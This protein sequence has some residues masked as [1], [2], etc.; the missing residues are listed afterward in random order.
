MHLSWLFIYLSFTSCIGICVSV[1][2]GSAAASL[3]ELAEAV[4]G[5]KLKYLFGCGSHSILSIYVSV[6][7]SVPVSVSVSVSV[8]CLCL[9]LWVC[10]YLCLNKCVCVFARSVGCAHK[11]ISFDDSL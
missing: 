2:D 7:V 6:S 3:I 1:D 8:L 4:L 11:R 10:L 9:N 5:K